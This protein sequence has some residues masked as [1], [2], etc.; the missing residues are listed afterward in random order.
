MLTFTVPNRAYEYAVK[1][2]ETEHLA[3]VTT[4]Q[5]RTAICQPSFVYRLTNNQL[6][7]LLQ[8]GT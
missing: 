5:R 7:V 8:Y 1:E 4:S 6:H 2:I 3:W